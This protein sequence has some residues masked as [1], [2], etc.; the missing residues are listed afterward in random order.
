MAI[1]PEQKHR[2]PLHR[3]V[4]QPVEM[5]G[6]RTMGGVRRDQQEQKLLVLFGTFRQSWG[7]RV[8]SRTVSKA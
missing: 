2:Q 5:Y 3:H 8:G 4:R 1:A 7:T 6:H